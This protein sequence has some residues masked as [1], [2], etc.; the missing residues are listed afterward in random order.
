MAAER[1]RQQ[2]EQAD[3]GRAKGDQ[4]AQ[5]RAARRDSWLPALL[6]SGIFL[7]LGV[8]VLLT[9][10]FVV[11]SLY[12]VRRLTGHQDAVT[13]VAVT[14]DGRYVVSGSWDSTVRVWELATGKEVRRLTGHLGDVESV[15]VTPDGRY[16]LSGGDDTTLRLWELATG[17][18]VRCF[19]GHE[20]NVTSVAVTPDGRYVVS[21]SW[22]RTVRI[23]ELTTGREVR[24]LTGHLFLVE[25][26]AVTPD[27]RYILSG[28]DDGT[29]RVWDLAT[30]NQVQQLRG[31]DVPV[32]GGIAATLDGR[33][34]VSVGS[35]A[36]H[37]GDVISNVAVWACDSWNV[38]WR[39]TPD[40]TFGPLGVPT[41]GAFRAPAV[42]PDGRYVVLAKSSFPFYSAVLVWEVATGNEVRRFETDKQ[43]RSLAVTP[44]G[45]YL[46][47]GCE[48]GTVRVWYLGYVRVGRVWDRLRRC[49]Q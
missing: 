20:D 29:L 38:V 47:C 6:V 44:D 32:I 15:A 17:E 25:S 48:D 4:N 37:F 27:G 31:S 35:T 14:P 34:V 33:Y 23:W 36:K 11:R 7:V 41:F 16:I 45:G 2:S 26:V 8:L 3:A 5:M 49:R 19:S 13:S 1:D 21:G 22:D 24:R 18:E 30:G 12:E 42:T 40:I 10:H 43:F 28:G 46:V 39:A 9:M